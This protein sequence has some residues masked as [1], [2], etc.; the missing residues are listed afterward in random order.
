MIVITHI[1]YDI[2][3]QT[4]DI[5]VAYEMC[6]HTSPGTELQYFCASSDLPN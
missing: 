2:H 1:M 4:N 6:E 3:I 5:T